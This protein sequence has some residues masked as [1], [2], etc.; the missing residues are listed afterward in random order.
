MCLVKSFRVKFT[1]KRGVKAP[2]PS[3]RESS[4]ALARGNFFLSL[5]V[6]ALYV[7]RRRLF[8]ASFIFFNASSFKKK[9][10]ATKWRSKSN[11][12][13]KWHW[14]IDCFYKCYTFIAF[15]TIFYIVVVVTSNF[16]GAHD[17]LVGQFGRKFTC[18]KNYVSVH[19]YNMIVTWNCFS[20][21]Q[22]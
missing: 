21:L 3:H 11:R 1:Q 20:L 10:I 19:T 4:L 6:V 22:F 5:I 13:I 8:S 18:W 12:Q 16:I 2:R 15:F 7:V 14:K 9:S 17:E